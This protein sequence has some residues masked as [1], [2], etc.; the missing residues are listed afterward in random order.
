MTDLHPGRKRSSLRDR[1]LAKVQKTDGCWNWTGYTR[2]G[3]GMIREG[4]RYCRRL[5]AHRLA[6][7]FFVSPIPNGMCVC[8]HCD[9]PT[10][11]NPQHLFVGS[12]VDNRADTV[13]KNRQARGERNGQA[14][15]TS[16]QVHAIREQHQA[17]SHQFGA[18]ALARRYGVHRSTIFDILSG[19]HW[20]QNP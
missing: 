18:K 1:F 20:R 7:E 13:A 10:C 19:E 14:K 6:Y 12:H 8:H 15:L 11:V 9:N 17:W 4:G 3:Y 2:K 16:R 5:Q